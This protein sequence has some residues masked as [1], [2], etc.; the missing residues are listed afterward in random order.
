MGFKVVREE[1]AL[2]GWC[3]G[4]SQ[5]HPGSA[6]WKPLANSSVGA[7][8]SPSLQFREWA[9]TGRQ[10]SQELRLRMVLTPPL[11][12]EPA[13]GTAVTAGSGSGS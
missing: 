12:P 9:G 11:D 8:A 5:A 6:G 10:G 7:V 3:L 4:D 1:G 2:G 13:P